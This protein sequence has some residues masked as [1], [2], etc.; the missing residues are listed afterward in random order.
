MSLGMPISDSERLTLRE[1]M[2][3]Q[4]LLIEFQSKKNKDIIELINTYFKSSKY[5][6]AESVNI[7]ISDIYNAFQGKRSNNLAKYRKEIFG[8]IEEEPEVDKE[9]IKGLFDGI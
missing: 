2:K 8:E 3:Y 9:K 6:I 5:I 4:E 7:A 1:A